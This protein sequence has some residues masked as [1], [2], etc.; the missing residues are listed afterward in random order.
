MTTIQKDTHTIRVNETNEKITT[1][2][3]IL[4]LKKKMH[5][6]E[7]LTLPPCLSL[8]LFV[9]YSLELNLKIRVGFLVPPSH[10]AHFAHVVVCQVVC[11][12]CSCM[13]PATHKAQFVETGLTVGDCSVRKP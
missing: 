7:F 8:Q 3:H 2:F 4:V 1:H 6:P 11:M 10:I 9:F 12:T 13:S 5:K